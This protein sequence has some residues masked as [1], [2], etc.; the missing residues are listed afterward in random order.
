MSKPY[1]DDLRIRAVSAV[2][3]GMSRHQ[4][5]KQF[6]V[7]VSSVIRWVQQH[8]QTGSVS[9]KLMGGSRGTRIEGADREWLL[10][11][12]KTQPDLTL[13]ELRRELAEQR[14]LMVGYGSV[15]RFCDR[16]KVSFKKKSARRSARPT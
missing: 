8:D 7:G 3:G 11:R 4:A 14:G 12:I 1:S 10:Q 13:E 6:S 2:A 15:W 9:P 5:S 16:E